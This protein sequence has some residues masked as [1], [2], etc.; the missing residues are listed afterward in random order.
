MSNIA[1]VWLIDVV[2]ALLAWILVWI[3]RE[4]SW[5]IYEPAVIGA[6][7]SVIGLT[8]LIGFYY[9][10]EGV[11]TRMR[12]SIA[13]GFSATYIF[14]L[15]SLLMIGDFRGSLSDELA[16]SVLDNFTIMVT[17]I[18]GFYFGSR[19]IEGVNSSIQARKEA[20]ALGIPSPTPPAPPSPSAA[21]SK[22]TARRTTVKGDATEESPL[23]PPRSAE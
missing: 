13:A 23:E 15:T 5:D 20:E 19:V 4:T 17:T 3:G 10:T 9:G 16:N 1:I 2:T 21:T 14:L 18:L 12:G 8:T 22:A 11:D 6:G 7:M